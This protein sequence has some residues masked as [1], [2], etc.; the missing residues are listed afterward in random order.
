MRDY[1]A[2]IK[3]NESGE[4]EKPHTLHEHLAGVAQLCSKY[5]KKFGFGEIGKLIGLL[6][7]AGKAS[8]AFQERIRL[9]SCFDV[10]AHLEGKTPKHVDHS[11]A[12]AQMICEISGEQLGRM[13]SYAI[14]GHHAGLPNGLDETDSHLTKRLKKPVEDYR[15]NFDTLD[16]LI[17]THGIE[18]L[19][20]RKGS[21]GFTLMFLIRM[22]FSCLV[23]SDFIDT[24]AYMQP[25]RFSLRE[26]PYEFSSLYDRLNSFIVDI[27][28]EKKKTNSTIAVERAKILDNCKLFAEQT[29]G[30]FSLTVPTGGGKTLSSMAFALRHAQLHQK[31]RIIYVIPYTSIIEQNAAVF[32]SALGDEVIL[33]HHSNFDPEN[34]TPQSRISSENWG[35]PVVVTTN[36]QFFE[37]LF[38]SKTSKCRKLHNISNSVIVLD[39]AQ[40][41]PPDYL[42]PTIRVIQELVDGFGC[43]IVLCTATQPALE[44]RNE[45]KMGINNIRHIITKPEEL[46][47]KFKRVNVSVIKNQLSDKYLSAK[48][49]ENKQVLCIVNTRK[50]ARLLFEL[51]G[52]EEGHFHLST[53]MCPKHR[54]NVLSEIKRRL[55]DKKICRLVSTQLIEAGV[56]ISFPVVYR[57]ETGI[58]SIAQAAGRCNREGEVKQGQVYVFHSETP[59]PPGMLRQ[60]ADQGKIT[61]S[62]HQ[63]DPIGLDA[64]YEYF[65]RYYWQRTEINGLDKKKIIQRCDEDLGRLNFPFKDVSKEYCLIE[66]NTRSIIIPWDEGESLINRIESRPLFP[67]RLVLRKLQRYTVAVHSKVFL[68]LKLA[69]AIRNIF[70]DGA[71]WILENKS[72]YSGEI[73]LSPENAYQFEPESLII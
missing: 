26:M 19:P 15:S 50:Q 5:S 46:Y 2:H 66:N 22:L 37:S 3:K 47:E 42:K 1:I 28:K 51:M 9:T 48:L 52:K 56:D 40:M 43:S 68:E 39:E 72:L 73:G 11:S 13:F 63:K 58:D 70:N 38:A 8:N 59:P 34:E 14:A 71:L 53:Y 55:D 29:P 27:A 64:V 65:R 20:F 10:E 35:A 18:K 60:S 62:H 21:D 69:G 49:I 30:F 45:F 32:R 44:K 4:F 17:Q 41:L 61:L 33:E 24:E 57:A 31:S 7:D 54:S 36:I 25:E 23:D 67:D 6:H 16:L 12:G